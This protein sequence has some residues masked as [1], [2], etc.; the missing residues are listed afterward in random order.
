VNDGVAKFDALM[1]WLME[2]AR[3]SEQ[4]AQLLPQLCGRL[5]DLGVA[6]AWS[7]IH[8]QTLH[9]DV[10]GVTI[11][12]RP[13]GSIRYRTS[14]VHA[15]RTTDVLPSPVAQMLE[16]VEEVR[17]RDLTL[18]TPPDLSNKVLVTDCV[19][20]PLRFLDGAVHAATW[21]TSTP[22]GFDA[23]AIDRL[24]RL[25]PALARVIEIVVLRRTSALLL[26]IYVGNHAGTRIL[27]G[28]IH[29]GY[30]E[31]MKAAIW[32]SDL[33]EFTTLSEALPA[34]TVVDILNQVFQC[35]I[36]SITSNGGEVLKFIGDGLLA[37]FPLNSAQPNVED[38]CER[39]MRAAE[40]VQSSIRGLSVRHE[41]GTVDGLKVGVALHFGEVLYGNVGGSSRGGDGKLPERSELDGTV[42]HT[43]RLDFTCVGSAVNF[44]ARLE[45]ISSLLDQPIVASRPF[46]NAVERQ[47]VDLGEF[48]VRGFV[49]PERVFALPA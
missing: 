29:R 38:A 22:G 34:R 6:L 36:A 48:E 26:D 42:L 40:E 45:R 47:W 9:P 43:S 2:G 30:V 46:C 33:R 49:R 35:Q 41:D 17:V 14:T 15:E 19:V 21:A 13:G 20:M 24:R 10:A 12:W 32:L 3:G 4:G 18:G 8:I 1:D 27:A 31:T 44:A 39:A 37:V 25:M 28:H 7:E 11:T 5:V 23:I 16:S